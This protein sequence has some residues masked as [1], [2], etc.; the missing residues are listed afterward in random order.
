[1]SANRFEIIEQNCITDF[2]FKN[3]PKVI[4]SDSIANNNRILLEDTK[5]T[6]KTVAEKKSIDGLLTQFALGTGG[7]KDEC[8]KQKNSVNEFYHNVLAHFIFIYLDEDKNL[9]EQINQISLDIENH[10]IDEVIER[11][12]LN[13]QQLVLRINSHT[14]RFVV[15]NPANANNL[16]GAVTYKRGTVEEALARYSDLFLDMLLFHADSDY[17]K[18]ILCELMV[19]FKNILT[20]E[21]PPI[22]NR[23]ESDKLAETWVNLIFKTSQAGYHIK[24]GHF[25]EHSSVFFIENQHLPTLTEL[26]QPISTAMKNHF[27]SLC[28]IVTVIDIASADLRFQTKA[29]KWAGIQENEQNSTF[30]RDMQ[31]IA[32]RMKQLTENYSD[33]KCI[34]AMVPLGCGAFGNKIEGFWSALIRNSSK[35]IEHSSLSLVIRDD[36]CFAFI[37]FSNQTNIDLNFNITWQTI[38]KIWLKS[39]EKDKVSQADINNMQMIVN[40]IKKHMAPLSISQASQ[41]CTNELNRAYFFI[42]KEKGE[43]FKLVFKTIIEFCTIL[44]GK[45]FQIYQQLLN[46][47][48]IAISHYDQHTGIR[49]SIINTMEGENKYLIELRKLYRD[50]HERACFDSRSIYDY[51]YKTQLIIKEKKSNQP[52]RD[53]PSLLDKSFNL[54]DQNIKQFEQELNKYM[55]SS[56]VKQMYLSK[57]FGALFPNDISDRITKELDETDT[58]NLFLTC[59]I[60]SK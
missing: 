39:C 47:F 48:E 58:K 42:N 54:L 55:P 26:N 45:R 1:M 2:I 30:D 8:W 15:T 27:L 20:N 7:V 41:R 38:D 57:F 29:L 34:L 25:H 51:L 12:K 19:V 24:P 18:A 21:K 31:L 16:C 37:R 44:L 52:D 33:Q 13:K 4:L 49:G 53:L 14:A 43:N 32:D 23:Q 28:T 11:L 10:K 56:W 36:N 22:N 17:Q 3:A 9:L 40:F 6:K 50:M 59:K 60:N 46:V 35:L 5:S